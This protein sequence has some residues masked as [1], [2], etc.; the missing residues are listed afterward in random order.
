MCKD[1]GA[2][3]KRKVSNEELNLHMDCIVLNKGINMRGVEIGELMKRGVANKRDA[4]KL[5]RLEAEVDTAMS[6]YNS[7]M[8]RI[9][10]LEKENG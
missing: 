4:R 7:Y 9:E 3:K 10:K 2:P 5:R 1:S 6:R 8:K